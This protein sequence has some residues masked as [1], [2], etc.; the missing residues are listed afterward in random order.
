MT[1]Q[2]WT[3]NGSDIWRLKE[4]RIFDFKNLDTGEV[5][6]CDGMHDV[7][8]AKFQ[9]VVMPEI[10]Q[11]TLK[12]KKQDVKKKKGKIAKSSRRGPR[13]KSKHK[14]VSLS[15]TPG[16]F[17]VQF[18]D[19]KKKTSVKLGTFNSELLAAAAYQDQ[20]GN[21]KEAKRLR[22]EYEE[23]DRRPEVSA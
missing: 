18:W 8:D 16:K 5:V 3:T 2:Y 11:Q 22:N 17:Q 7:M 21:K 23:G 12:V 15:K 14:G 4:R 6:T 19:K 9:P 20:I 1:A 10:K 13:S